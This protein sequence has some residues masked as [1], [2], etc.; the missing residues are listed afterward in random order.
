[1]EV[2]YVTPNEMNNLVKRLRKGERVICPLCEKGILETRGNH[3]TSPGFQCNHCK[4]R[5]NIN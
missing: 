2:I 3:K 1:M 5:L 4:K